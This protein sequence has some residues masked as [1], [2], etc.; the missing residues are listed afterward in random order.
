M[1]LIW[2]CT[3]K[4]LALEIRD[5]DKTDWV[6]LSFTDKLFFICTSEM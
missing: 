4:F 3:M 5:L 6:C 2:S 1:S